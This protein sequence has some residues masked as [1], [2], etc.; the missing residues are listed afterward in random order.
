MEN[1]EKIH[2]LCPLLPV[3]S[4][5][6]PKDPNITFSQ[7]LWPPLIYLLIN[8]TRIR[9]LQILGKS[10]NNTQCHETSK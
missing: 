3:L 4:R 1:N 6:Q 10:R 8:L 7:S 2:H 9:Q 5:Y